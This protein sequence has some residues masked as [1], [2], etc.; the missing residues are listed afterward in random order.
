MRRG[1]GYEE[2]LSQRQDHD[3]SGSALMQVERH[4]QT[5][6]ECRELARALERNDALINRRDGDVTI[7]PFATIGANTRHAGGFLRNLLAGGTVVVVLVGALV[8]AGVLVDLRSRPQEGT[9]AASAPAAVSCS[10]PARPQYIPFLSSPAVESTYDGGARG[11]RYT[12]TNGSPNGPEYVFVGHQPTAPSWVGSGH[13]ATAGGRTVH[14]IWVGDPGVGEISAYWQ[15]SGAC[16][17]FVTSLVLRQGSAQ[18]IEAEL[19]R[20]IGS[21]P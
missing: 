19:L 5:C 13:T 1:H 10:A 9:V 20:V 12:S 15:E 18:Q 21:L 14:V 16:S 11:T 8:V 3:L 4:L 7:P 2:R 6:S 17:Y